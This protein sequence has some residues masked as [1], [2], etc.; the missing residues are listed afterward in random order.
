[1]KVLKV[2][3]HPCCKSLGSKDAKDIQNIKNLIPDPAVLEGGSPLSIYIY[4][5]TDIYRRLRFKKGPALRQMQGKSSLWHHG[6]S[7]ALTPAQ[8][9]TSSFLDPF[10]LHGDVVSVASCFQEGEEGITQEVLTWVGSGSQVKCRKKFLAWSCCSVG[11]KSI[12][13][14]QELVVNVRFPASHCIDPSPV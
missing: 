9:S 4:M 1:M 5:A 8:L 10:L 3:L 12:L 11:S 6:A 2:T 7:T 14:E 13:Q